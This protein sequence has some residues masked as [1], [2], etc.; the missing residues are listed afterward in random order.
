MRAES[1]GL[2]VEVEEFRKEDDKTSFSILKSELK[3]K[4]YLIKELSRT[5]KS[6]LGQRI[7]QNLLWKDKAIILREKL[8]AQT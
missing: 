6:K 4:V 5:R 7:V 1:T 8:Q 3:S 2:K